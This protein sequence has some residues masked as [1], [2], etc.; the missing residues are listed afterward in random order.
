MSRDDPADPVGRVLAD[1]YRIVEL[2]ARG[3][4][5]R[6]YRAH[7]TRLDRDI[8]LKI[9]S[10]PY[11][12]QPD[13][14]G[15]FLSEARS[16]ASI[17]HPN[18]VHV[19]DSGSDDGLHYLAMELL[20]GYRSLR[21]LL[22]MGGPLAPERAVAIGLEVLSGLRAVHARGLL[23]CD[24]KS[25]NVM[26]R[27]AAVKLIDFGISRSRADEQPAGSSIGSL[28]YMAPE[29]LR[30][31]P[32]TPASDLFSVGVVLYESVTGDVPFRGSSPDEVAGQQLRGAEPPRSRNAAV[33]AMLDGT[34][35]R[36]LHPEP[37]HR[38]AT[39]DEMTE[40]LR[41]SRLRHPTEPVP[42]AAA[43]PGYVAP[44]A[45]RAPAPWFPQAGSPP[46][47]PAS[48]RGYPVPQAHDQRRS[49]PWGAIAVLVT[50]LALAGLAVIGLSGRGLAGP[51]AGTGPP[52][53]AGNPPAALPPGKVYVPVVVGLSEQEA[54][55][56]ANAAQLEW[57]LHW[58]V[59]PDLSPGIYAQSPD[60]GSVVNVGSPF[61]LWSNR[62]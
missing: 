45:G 37:A 30:G 60:P 49:A 13:D 22:R 53:G 39:A 36:A 6:V 11:A 40:A 43:P 41:K 52:P 42:L 61:E 50:L 7:D 48:R 12:E 10:G 54:V 18:L 24:V 14:V 46:A 27:D 34:I 44:S 16:A 35:L 5:G 1:R 28:H 55:A 57:T 38:F 31:E 23:H 15:R 2:L 3:G 8:A 56:A 26:V 47:Y 58:R 25:A 20:A 33:P 59:R 51:N 4:M 32:L 17:S 19:Y 9:L 62:P 21:D 29:Q